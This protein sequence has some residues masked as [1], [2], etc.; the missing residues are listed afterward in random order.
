MND[1]NFPIQAGG[2]AGVKANGIAGHNHL[3]PDDAVRTARIPFT[4][5]DSHL[6]GSPKSSATNDSQLR[7]AD[8]DQ[9]III[10]DWDDTLCPSTFAR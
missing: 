5:K 8:S 7:Y 6:S 3:H 9:T 1:A 10:F 2:V 4:S